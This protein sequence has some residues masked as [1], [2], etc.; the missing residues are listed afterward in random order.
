MRCDEQWVSLGWHADRLVA[1]IPLLSKARIWLHLIC[2]ETFYFHS[3]KEF[4]F[5]FQFL[6]KPTRQ[7]CSDWRKIWA[8]QCYSVMTL[9]LAPLLMS[10]VF[11]LGEKIARWK[12]CSICTL[13]SAAFHSC[14]VRPVFLS[15]FSYVR[16]NHNFAEHEKMWGSLLGNCRSVRWGTTPQQTF[17]HSSTSCFVSASAHSYLLLKVLNWNG[18]SVWRFAVWGIQA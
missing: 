6:M 4:Y 13:F 16:R 15:W 11:L 3:F 5:Y 18:F 14:G 17:S 10:R 8:F 7:G 1:Q 12:K 2:K 9:F